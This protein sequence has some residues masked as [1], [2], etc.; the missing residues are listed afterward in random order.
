MI[1][2]ISFCSDS[3]DWSY[4]NAVIGLLLVLLSFILIFVLFYLRFVE[5]NNEGFWTKMVAF[6]RSRSLYYTRTNIMYMQDLNSSV[7]C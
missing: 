5:S 6:I 2:E 3:I 4:A 7:L 1:L